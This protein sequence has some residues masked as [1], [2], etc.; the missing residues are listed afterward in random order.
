MKFFTLAPV[1]AAVAF[2]AM[3]VVALAA[4]DIVRGINQVTQ[5]SAS[6]RDDTNSITITTASTEFPVVVNDFQDI[7]STVSGLTQSIQE[8]EGQPLSDKDAQLVVEAL[9]AFVDVHKA[10]LDAVIGK[11]SLAAQFFF[12]API[13]S[14]LRSLEGV[15]DALADALIS[16]IP[17][18]A[19]AANAQFSS[20]SDTLNLAITTYSS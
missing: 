10:L 20:L 18:Q 5:L 11:H 14:A 12:T 17:T 13:A 8:Q 16:V 15:V 3:N 2:G 6:T 19:P 9:T 7:I 4:S 1:I